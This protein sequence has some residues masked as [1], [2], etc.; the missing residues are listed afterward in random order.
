VV[1]GQP[2]DVKAFVKQV[3]TE[4]APKP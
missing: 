3:A 1:H 2:G 4:T